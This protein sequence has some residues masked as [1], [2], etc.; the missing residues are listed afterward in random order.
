[1]PVWLQRRGNPS[2]LNYLNGREELPATLILGIPCDRTVNYA[3]RLSTMGK[4]MELTARVSVGRRLKEGRRRYGQKCHFVWFLSYQLG[5]YYILMCSVSYSKLPHFLSVL[6]Q[7][8][9]FA[10]SHS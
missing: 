6:R 9:V 1:M 8:H 5:G 10:V 7:I 3:E 4:P 2:P